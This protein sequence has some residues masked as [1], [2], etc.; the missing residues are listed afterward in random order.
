MDFDKEL[1]VEA[2]ADI[3]NASKFN[4][5]ILIFGVRSGVN[6]ESFAFLHRNRKFINPRSFAIMC[7]ALPNRPKQKKRTLEFGERIDGDFLVRFER[8]QVMAKSSQ[9]PTHTFDFFDGN[10]NV[11][12]VKLTIDVSCMH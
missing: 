4:V 6:F 11:T 9:F 8:H 1:V 3:R 2:N 7:R 5:S 10:I 12:Y